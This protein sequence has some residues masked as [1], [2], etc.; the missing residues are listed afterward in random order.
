MATS[1]SYD[2]NQTT[3]E[4][5]SEALKLCGVIEAGE[6]LSADALSDGRTALQRMVKAW[7]GKGSHLWSKKEGVLFLVKGQNRYALGAGTTDHATEE[8]ILIKTTLA[9]NA[10]A[11]ATSIT[12]TDATGIA[13]AYKIGV[14]QDDG[15]YHW[16]TVN[17]APVG[18]VVTLTAGMASLA[19]S[20][21][22]VFAYETDLV[23][24]LRVLDVRRR[25]ESAD[26]DIPIITFSRQGY[27][28]TPN[29]TTQSLV[30]QVYYDPQLTQGQMYTWPTPPNILST[31]RFTFWKPL[32]DMDAVNNDPDFPQ[33]WLDAMTYGLAVRLC[34][35]YGVPMQD[36]MWLKQEAAEMLMEAMAFDNEPESVYF[37]P[38]M[39][40]EGW[41]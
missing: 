11:S 24:P 20:G 22:R 27:M 14:V 7:Q 32:Q 2:F 10:A 4:I 15:T 18:N 31:L 13:T 9:A 19:T 35:Q 41:G 29:K 34:P 3:T 39:T 33:E 5:V 17:G 8:N 36:R 37:Q 23:R 26:Q 30:T 6:T 16:T 1:E 25:D 40:Y 12:L 21:N 28:E 38:D